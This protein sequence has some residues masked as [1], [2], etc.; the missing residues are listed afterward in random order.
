VPDLNP[1]RMAR[2]IARRLLP[3]DIRLR[4]ADWVAQ[5][6]LGRLDADVVRELDVIDRELAAVRGDEWKTFR[7]GRS[8]ANMSERV[9]EVPWVL[10]RYRSQSKVLDVGT[11]SAFPR[12]LDL[13]RRLHVPELYGVDL[14]P[15]RIPMIQMAVGD[16][17]HLP[18]ANGS[19]DLILCISTIEHVGLD[20]SGY[21]VRADMDS[22][23]D[24]Q[25][26][27]ELTRVLAR[28]GQLLITLPFGASQTFK[29]FRQYDLAAW[30]RLS[31]AAA[32]EVGELATYSL[33]DAGWAQCSPTANP[34]GGFQQSGARGARGVL[35]ARVT[36][37]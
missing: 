23:G 18:Y 4:F 30:Q 27:R 33:N 3:D 26:L 1:L 36:R 14:R 7:S 11:A 34:T 24:V 29:W 37:Q 21:G 13:L 9:V 31:D 17:R 16:V 19:F 5:G 25:A 15:R 28:G 2:P 20:N 8:T 22:E 12:Y 10:S 6:P 32:V 35:C